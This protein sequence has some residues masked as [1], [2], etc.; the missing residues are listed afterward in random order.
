MYLHVHV[1]TQ[2]CGR[3]GRGG[4]ASRAHLFMSTNQKCGDQVK[5]YFTSTE[6]CRRQIML[7]ALGVAEHHPPSLPCCDCC[8]DTKCPQSLRFECQVIS[9][10][11]RRKRRT[12]Q[13]EV[14][15]ECKVVLKGALLKAVDA[16]MAEH[17]SFLMLGRNFVCPECIIDEICREAR[18]FKSMDDLNITGLRPELK[19]TF[20]N[21]ICAVLSSA[22]TPKKRCM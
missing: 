8:D 2:L 18:F 7:R 4:M 9:R 13:H 17:T 20:F 12:A 19:N 6:N 16:Y 1:Y 15:E 22:P 10:C 11:N 21:I 14:D 3:A 5:E